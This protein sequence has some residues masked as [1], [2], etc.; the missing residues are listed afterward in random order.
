MIRAEALFARSPPVR[1]GPVSFAFDAGVHAVLGRREDGVAL[2][3]A[4][5]A[6]RVRRYVGTLTFLGAGAPPRHAVAYVPLDAVLPDALDVDEVLAVAAGIRREPARPASQ[7]LAVLGLAP[8]TSRPVRS[9][10]VA[11]VRA[12]AIAE[13]V[14]SHARIVLLE[15]PYMALDPRAAPHLAGALRDKARAGACVVVGTASPRDAVS[16]ADDVLVL[17]RGLS[18]QS[19]VPV[20]PAERKGARLRLRASDP[21]ALLGSLATETAVHDVAFDGSALLVGGADPVELA[22]AVARGV[23]RSGVRLDAMISDAPEV[24]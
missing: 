14:T 9:L 13:A 24:A 7:R 6:G 16:L 2:L 12:V 5:L 3:L 10:T 4:V 20:A 23:L 1:V 11:E 18:V 19:A 21:R 17:D 8:L 15:E 22:E